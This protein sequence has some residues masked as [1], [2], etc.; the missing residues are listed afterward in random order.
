VASEC[1][2]TELGSKEKRSELSFRKQIANKGDQLIACALQLRIACLTSHKL[3]GMVRPHLLRLGW[4]SLR[5]P[6]AVAEQRY[7]FRLPMAVSASF[8]LLLV[9]CSRAGAFYLP[10]VAPQ[11][12]ARGD[13]LNI[14]VNKLSSTRNLPYEHYS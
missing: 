4:R 6:A 1:K 3:V 14:K 13:K 5:K 7:L 9:L 8:L 11:D 10:G 12:F 2:P